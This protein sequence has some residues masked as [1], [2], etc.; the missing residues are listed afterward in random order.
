VRTQI[1]DDAARTRVVQTFFNP[2]SE[3]LEGL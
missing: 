1:E 2:A 3:T